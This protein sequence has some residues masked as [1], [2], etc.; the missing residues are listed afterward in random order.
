MASIQQ[1]VAIVVRI[2]TKPPAPGYESQFPSADEKT[3][4][5]AVN[6]A[7]GEGLDLEPRS[8]WLLPPV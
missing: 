7:P 3:E 2:L 6:A 4:P 1:R 8:L 5:P